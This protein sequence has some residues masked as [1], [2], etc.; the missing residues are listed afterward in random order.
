MWAFFA[1]LC[2]EDAQESGSCADWMKDMMKSCFSPSAE[3]EPTERGE[4]QALHPLGYTDVAIY[5]GG[6]VEWNTDRKLPLEPAY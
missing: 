1:S 3:R 5:C 4:A 2:S 6:L